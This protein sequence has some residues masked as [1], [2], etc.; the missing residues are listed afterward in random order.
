M[1]RDTAIATK[2]Y[3][4]AFTQLFMAHTSFSKFLCVSIAFELVHGHFAAPRLIDDL[5]KTFQITPRGGTHRSR[6]T[7]PNIFRIES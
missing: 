4:V 6:G 5:V 7:G 1:H 3:L 2:L